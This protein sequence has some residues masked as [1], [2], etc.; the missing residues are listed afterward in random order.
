MSH[1]TS[2]WKPSP[3][4]VFSESK[5]M[6]VRNGKLQWKWVGEVFHSTSGL[7][8]I[9]A[10]FWQHCLRFPNP[11]LMFWDS[12][13]ITDTHTHTHPACL[14]EKHSSFSGTDRKPLTRANQ[15]FSIPGESVVGHITTLWKPCHLNL[16]AISVWKKQNC[17]H[18]LQYVT[19]IQHYTFSMQPVKIAIANVKTAILKTGIYCNI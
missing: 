15:S 10:A 8:L 6:L 1:L 18:T 7:Q 14:V 4:F 12:G 3:W 5:Y 2:T 11:L 17:I 19:Y 9:L 16:L 13:L